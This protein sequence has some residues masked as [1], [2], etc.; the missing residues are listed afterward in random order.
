[1]L[2]RIMICLLFFPFSV[3]CQQNTIERSVREVLM[4]QETA[5]NAGDLK[6]YM[7]GYWKSDSLKFI[8]K[9]GI[10]YG[11]QMTL[12]NYLKSY[13]DKVT[14]GILK[15]QIINIETFSDSAAFV[16]GKWDLKREMGNINGYFTLLFK[17]VD[18]SW[19]IVCDHSS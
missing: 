2:I 16:V 8:G 13:P 4:K 18:N 1:M 3:K 5:W 10:Q 19:A 14:M 17:K 11:W 15:F 7:E 6:E 9:S 12:D